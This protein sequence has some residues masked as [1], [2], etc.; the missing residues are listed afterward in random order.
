MKKIILVAA[1]LTVLVSCKKE[2][3]TFGESISADGAIS[4][5]EM[6][7]K[8]KDLKD[9]DTLNVTF[10]S[11]TKEV[12]QSKGCWMTMDLDDESEAV[13]KFKDY[14]FFV[15]KNG[16]DKE[17]IVKGKAYVSVESVAQL[18]HL[19]K[20]AG[21]SQAAIDSISSPKVTYSFM[22]DGVLMAK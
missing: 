2:Y 8:F 9:G 6:I 18:K 12:C 15:P 11:K 21:K 19:A 10:K 5:E 14:A 20:D 16:Q 3:A 22:A 13:V 17:T 7:A 4:K 1:I